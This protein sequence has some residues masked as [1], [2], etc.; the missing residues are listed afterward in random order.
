MGKNLKE[1]ADELKAYMIDQ[2]SDSHNRLN[3]RP[4]RYNNLKFSMDI[5]KEQIPH[6]VISLGMSE[7]QFNIRNGEKMNGGLG[8]DEKF[9]YRWFNKANTLPSLNECWVTI[10]KERGRM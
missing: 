6:V 8:A 5:A 4:E 1:L 2:Q 3:V 9:V 7:A 10:A